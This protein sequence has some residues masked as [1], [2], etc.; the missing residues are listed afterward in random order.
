MLDRKKIIERAYNECMTEMYAKAQPSVD[1]NELLEGV[2]NGKIID[3]DKEPVHDRYYLS[4]EEFHYILD[5]YVNAYG[6]KE[7]WTSNL[8]L[9]ERYF[10]GEGRKD[11]WIPEKVD[12]DGF[13]HPGYRSSEAVP[14]IKETFKEILNN[15]GDIKVDD[16]TLNKIS[17]KLANRVLTYIADCKDFYRFDRD[18]TSFKAGIALGASPTSNKEIVEKYWKENGVNIEI[19]ERNPNLLWDKDYY[20]DDFVEAM[21]D[22]YGKNWEKKTWDDYYNTNNGKKK[23]VLDYMRKDAKYDDYYIKK[24][25]NGELC[26]VCFSNSDI[27]INIDDFIKEKK[28]KGSYGK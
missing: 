28:I 12:D 9:L 15:C 22:I 7:T 16:E 26:I 17:N 27:E 19:K 20:G 25:D 5:K 18:E 1:F 4:Y 2:K 13:R 11:I 3:T 10:K 6:L 21:V 8:E 14:H 24:S 23:I